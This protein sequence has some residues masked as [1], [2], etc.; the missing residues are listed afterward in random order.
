MTINQAFFLIRHAV[1]QV[2]PRT[3]TLAYSYP[4]GTSSSHDQVSL[5]LTDIKISARLFMPIKS[6]LGRTVHV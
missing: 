3:E 5:L 1:W 6:R 2:Y 4:R